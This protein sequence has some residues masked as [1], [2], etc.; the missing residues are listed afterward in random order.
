MCRY[1]DST[2]DE[3]NTEKENLSGDVLK[4]VWDLALLQIHVVNSHRSPYRLVCSQF[5]SNDAMKPSTLARHF[6]AKQG[7]AEG[8]VNLATAPGIRRVKL[9]NEK[10]T[11]FKELAHKE[12]LFPHCIVH[13]HHLAAKKLI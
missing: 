8:R 3:L 7:R 10:A 6:H 9:K 12:M 1:V 4:N 2:H 11:K 5:I 13:L